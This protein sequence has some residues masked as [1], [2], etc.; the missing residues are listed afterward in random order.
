M[1]KMSF[2]GLNIGWFYINPIAFEVFNFKVHWY[3]IIIALGFAL[4]VLYCIKIKD[5]ANVSS[6]NILDI[7][8]YGAPAGIICARLYYVIFSFSEYKDN[9]WDIFKIWNGGIAI[10]GAVIGAVISAYIYCRVKK[11]N[12]AKVFD[13]CIMGVL[14]G[15]IIGRWGNFVNG[16]AHGGE[17]DF[18]LR[19][20]LFENGK[21]IFVHPTFLYESLW[22]VGV[23]LVLRRV[24]K[25]RRFDGEVFFSYLCLYSLGRF[26][27][28]GMRTDSLYLAGM[29]ISQMLAALLVVLS[30]CLIIYNLKKKNKENLH[31]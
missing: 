14:I 24:M 23:F 17:T 30:I 25:K 7:A 1:T 11:L 28:E 15:Q 6:D 27:I 2:P 26:W 5:Y 22:N 20:G 10:Y 9:L 13:V 12:I 16:E 21:E 3:G 8:I 31:Q 29:R 4:A 19:M 18:I